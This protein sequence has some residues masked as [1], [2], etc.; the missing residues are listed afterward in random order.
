MSQWE[1]IKADIC[2]LISNS[3]ATAVVDDKNSVE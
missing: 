1:A 2:C 3:A